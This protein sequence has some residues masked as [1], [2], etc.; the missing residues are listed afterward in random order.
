VIQ[1]NV[2]LRFCTNQNAAKLQA[3][4]DFQHYCVVTGL[5]QEARPVQ[6][7]YEL[8]GAHVLGAGDFPEVAKCP[9]NILPIIRKYHSWRLGGHPATCLDLVECSPLAANRKPMAR[10]IW[11]VENVHEQFRPAVFER[12]RRL[13]IEGSKLYGSKII[14]RRD[15]ALQILS[16]AE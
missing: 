12:L 4:K 16:E 10:L 15:E 2:N 7:G 8:D 11:L 3:K 9:D 6:F 13:F 5:S 14:S 1:P